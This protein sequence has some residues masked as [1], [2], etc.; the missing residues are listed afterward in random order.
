MI[1][2]NELKELQKEYQEV[3]EK[4]QELKCK[5]KWLRISAMKG[6]EKKFNIITKIILILFGS[7]FMILF[8]PIN[9]IDHLFDDLKEKIS[10]LSRLAKAKTVGDFRCMCY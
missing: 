1:K 7:I 5:M 4:E 6:N 2:E 9:I 10:M 3:R 8:V